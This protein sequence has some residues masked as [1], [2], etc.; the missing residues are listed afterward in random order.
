MEEA[1]DLLRVKARD[2]DA[3]SSVS[4]KGINIVLISGGD[5]KLPDNFGLKLRDM[6]FAEALRFVTEQAGVK[7]RVDANAVVVTETE[8][9][10]PQPPLT[11]ANALTEREKRLLHSL[12]HRITPTIN[13]YDCAVEEAVEFLRVNTGCYDEAPPASISAPRNIVLHV[14][15]NLHL[16]R[17]TLD[18]QNISLLEALGYMAEMTGLK[19]SLRSSALA[20]SDHDLG[21]LP[22]TAIQRTPLGARA[23]RITLLQIYS[24]ETSL[25]ETLEF[26]HAKVRELAPQKQDVN[27]VV[28]PGGGTTVPYLDLKEVSLLN[29]LD[30]IALQSGHRLSVEGDA[31]VLTPLEEPH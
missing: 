24:Q 13:L 14:H 9:K 17:I 16:R 11:A 6:P 18:L 12:S 3:A 27:I 20:F 4:E 2:A 21:R 28:R 26:V 30:H 1:I 8:S 29:A 23:S 22:L 7:F 31:F 19:L 5:K 10:P 25:E 15:N